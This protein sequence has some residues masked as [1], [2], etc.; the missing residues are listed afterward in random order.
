MW[1]EI[2]I[3]AKSKFYKYLVNSHCLQI[4]LTKS[5]PCKIPEIITKFKFSG[6]NPN[7][8]ISANNIRDR[9]IV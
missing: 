5:L 1:S 8:L 9:L 2:E 3:M 4:Y 6:H 7:F